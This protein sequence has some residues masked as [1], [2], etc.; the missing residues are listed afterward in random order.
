MSLSFKN[1]GHAIASGAKHFEDYAKNAIAFLEKVQGAEP[2]VALVLQAVAPKASE[3]SDL[4]FHILGDV[5][6]AIEKA[7]VAG[8][9]LDSA[10]AA[11]GL[12]VQMDLATIGAI[13]DAGATIKS[14]IS[15]IG[16]QY[17]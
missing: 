12:N 8:V 5:V 4:A 13:K 3:Y 15:S 17:K 16:A 7:E 14:V 10:A 6:T 9:Q 11:N 2:A 1:L